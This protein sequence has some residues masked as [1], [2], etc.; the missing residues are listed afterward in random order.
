MRIGIRG[1]RRATARAIVGQIE[2]SETGERE[3]S[4]KKYDWRK[5]ILEKL[6]D[7][8]GQLDMYGRIEKFNE[9]T[10]GNVN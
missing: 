1:A 8:V 4:G 10:A 7:T 6:N 5:K 3:M 2:K 9:I